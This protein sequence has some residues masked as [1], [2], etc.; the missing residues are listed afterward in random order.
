M[1]GSASL[2]VA[3]SYSV[4]TSILVTISGGAQTVLLIHKSN[5]GTPDSTKKYKFKMAAG[6]ILLRN[7]N[8]SECDKY[9]EG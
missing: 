8:P 7:E 1:G 5:N 6:Y 3:E 4:N 9:S 2:L